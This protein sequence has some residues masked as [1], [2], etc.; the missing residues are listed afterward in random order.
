M[1]G[2]ARAISEQPIERHDGAQPRKQRQEDEEHHASRHREQPVFIELGI[3]PPEDVPPPLH[4]IFQG[5]RPAVRGR[6]GRRVSYA[7]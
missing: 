3:R 5:Y 7:G 2:E 4:G 6:A 1:V